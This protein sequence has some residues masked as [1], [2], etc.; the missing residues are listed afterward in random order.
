M[1]MAGPFVNSLLTVEPDLRTICRSTLGCA[2]VSSQRIGAGRNSRVFRV[3][4]DGPVDLDSPDGPNRL[5]GLNGQLP[6][7]VVVKF[8]RRDAGD[9]RDRLGTEFGSLQ[10]L[11]ENGVRAIPRPIVC[12]PNLDCGIYEY[13]DGEVASSGVISSQDIDES[14]AFLHVL[15]KLRAVR[16][17]EALPIASEACFS[18]ADIFGSIDQRLERLMQTIL[19]RSGP[20]HSVHGETAALREWIEETFSPLNL[21]VRQWCTSYAL[22]HG[23]AFEEPLGREARTLSPSDFGFHNAIRRPDGSLTFVDFEYFGWDDPAKT[24][25]DYLLH[26][27]MTLGDGLRRHFA[28]QALGAFAGVPS[29]DSRVHV[30]YPLFGLKWALILLN[31]F[32]PE[33]ENQVSAELREELQ[34]TQLRKAQHFIGCLAGDYRQNPYLP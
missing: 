33:R 29:L 26:P 22:R 12:A 1:T 23:I 32:L 8:Y 31:Q 15:E 11:W 21:E 25:V 14:V 4:L 17:S 27:G 10:F 19:A 7:S 20:N 3:D 5:V 16:G 34:K 28:A 13:I 30:V 18:I 24:I 2:A 6:S 9:T